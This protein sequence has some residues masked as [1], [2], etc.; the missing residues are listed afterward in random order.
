MSQQPPDQNPFAPSPGFVPPGGE[1]PLLREDE[2]VR[3]P[4]P[5]TRPLQVAMAAYLLVSAVLGLALS[6][7]YKDQ[8]RVAI[9]DQVQ[10]SVATSGRSMTPEALQQ[11]SDFGVMGVFGAAI[12]GLV[13]ALVLAIL[14]LAKPRTWVLIVDLVFLGLGALGVF[15]GPGANP[16]APGAMAPLSFLSALVALAIFVAALVAL[17]RIGPWAMRKVPA[18]L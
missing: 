11:A 10:K 9:L 1:S 2:F 12:I 8:L 5:Y 18:T 14:S 15:R 16:N 6:L 17:I 7:A 3:E 13:I 4:T